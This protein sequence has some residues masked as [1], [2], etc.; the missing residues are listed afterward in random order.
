MNTGCLHRATG[1]V[2][3]LLA[4]AFLLFVAPVPLQAAGTN[5]AAGVAMGTVSIY[6]LTEASGIAAS[7]LNPGVLWTCN[8]GS[9]RYVF[10]LSPTGVQLAS[11][12]INTFVDDT[13]DIAVGPG[14]SNG[15]TCIYIGDIGG[16]T[17]PSGGRSSVKIV[18]IPEPVVDISW[19]GSPRSLTLSGIERFTL[20][21]TNSGSYDAE[22]LMVDP[23]SGDI[24]VATKQDNNSRLYRANVMSLTN[25]ST[26]TMEYLETVAFNLVSGGDIS[27]DGTQIVLRREDYAMSWSRATNESVA[28]AMARSGYSIPV[29]GPPTEP[30]GEAIGLLPDG[31]GYV[32]ISEGGTDPILYFFES[33]DPSP[34]RFTV[35]PT[36][37]QAFLGG[38]ATFTSLAAGYPHPTYQWSF[39]G[40]NLAGE[41]NANLVRTNIG[42]NQ[43]GVY[44]ISISNASGNV[45]TSATLT[46]SGMPDLRITEVMASPVGSAGVSNANWWEL[47]SFEAQT[48]DLSGWR[49]NDNTGGLAS[50]PFVIPSG[51]QIQ[52]GESII[53]CEDLA[54]TNF[55][56]WW[57]S[58]NLPANIQIV[59][60]TGLGLSLSSSGDGVRLWDAQT[61][62]VSN[63]VTSVDFGASTAGVSF[64]YD[65]VTSQFGTN[66]QLG[67][68]GVFK[69]ALTPDIGSPGRING[70]AT[71]PSLQVSTTNGGIRITFTPVA[72]FHYSLQTRADILNGAWEITQDTLLA[73]NSLP[74]SFD[75]STFDNHDYYRIVVE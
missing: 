4:L 53:F 6:P 58:S 33:L 73:T 65:P 40:Q 28:T 38:S 22:C 41:T 23:I 29:I 55:I 21:Y 9:A 61:T 75:K 67:I 66:S 37:Q 43:V 17:F 44:T 48:V 32:T 8:D 14:P 59:D 10:A 50:H 20:V 31:S 45:S 11:G 13:E 64:N 34:A 70:P 51:V 25:G 35:A 52:P 7:R 62:D 12:G 69:A 18:R 5:Y 60:F 56:K 2:S 16:N 3:T 47:T 57:G 42:T 46:V 27:A 24:L 1:F 72:G 68:N 54:S 26:V 39:G 74:A 49:Y 19:A 30:N 71:S 63:T 15:S 36:D